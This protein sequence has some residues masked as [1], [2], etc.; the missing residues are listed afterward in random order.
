MN[1]RFAQANALPNIGRAKGECHEAA[2]L[3][4]QQCTERS[5]NDDTKRDAASEEPKL[6]RAANG[7]FVGITMWVARPIQ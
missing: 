6:I 7:F 2:P 4:K 5:T 3:R 1:E